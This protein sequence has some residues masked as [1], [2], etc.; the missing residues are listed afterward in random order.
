MRE[1]LPGSVLAQSGSFPLNGLLAPCF[2][3]AHLFLHP[4]FLQR[5]SNQYS[6]LGL[7]QDKM[8]FLAS[9]D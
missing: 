4:H 8:S 1:N 2:I 7:I 3:I 9:H 6:V 5:I